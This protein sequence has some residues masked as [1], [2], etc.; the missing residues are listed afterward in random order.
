[1]EKQNIHISQVVLYIVFVSIV[2]V[3]GMFLQIKIIKRARQEK[4]VTWKTEIFHSI[5]MII[6]FSIVLF[7]EVL[8]YVIPDYT[9]GGWICTLSRFI[10][11]CGIVTISSHSL[12]ISVQKYIV[13]VNSIN[14]NSERHILE[15]VLLVISVT[16][17]ILWAAATFIRNVSSIPTYSSLESC[18]ALGNWWGPNTVDNSDI[19]FCKFGRNKGYYDEGKFIYFTTEVYCIAQTSL[20]V[21]IHFNIFEAFVYYKIFRFINR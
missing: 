11:R 5:V 15:I 6:H 3:I 7:L 17:S 12:L 10:R 21:M 1:M 2:F 8:V 18:F 20:S 4:P 19:T 13:I 16:F 9:G 14:G